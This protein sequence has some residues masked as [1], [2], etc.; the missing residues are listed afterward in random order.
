MECRSLA[1]KST[2]MIHSDFLSLTLLCCR[3]RFTRSNSSISCLTLSQSK[4]KEHLSQQSIEI[5]INKN[6]QKEEEEE[7]QLC[8]VYTIERRS[9]MM[10]I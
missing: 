1:V 9:F 7:H 5:G 10:F 3:L 6:E 8:A 4:Y 2:D